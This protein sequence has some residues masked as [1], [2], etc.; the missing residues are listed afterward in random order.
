M[1]IKLGKGS[2]KLAIVNGLHGDEPEGI[3][4]FQKI[5]KDLE[6]I[7]K[8]NQV[9]IALIPMANL[10]A[11]SM[12]SRTGAD[13]VDL[14]RQFTGPIKNKLAKEIYKLIKDYEIIIDLH[15]M[16]NA[17]LDLTGILIEGNKEQNQTNLKLLNG[18][19]IKYAFRAGR[20]KSKAGS[21]LQHHINNGKT[22]IALEI[23]NLPDIRRNHLNKFLNGVRS[24]FT[25][26]SLGT[27][28]HIFIG[29]REIVQANHDGLFEPTVFVGE[30]VKPGQ[31]I[32]KI[33]STELKLTNLIVAKGGIILQLKK[34][35][36]LNKDETT[37][38]LLTNHKL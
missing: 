11:L 9:E 6:I 30:K 17:N 8:E 25:T 35:Q 13:K 22:G 20:E 5:V 33:I 31:A 27:G 14:N 38:T 3:F 12:K 23:P 21:L 28:H 7:A 37:L 19:Q 10:E 29:D 2:K 15:T 36:Y 1:L 32:G 24:I 34:R 18:F 26:D 4:I 16:P